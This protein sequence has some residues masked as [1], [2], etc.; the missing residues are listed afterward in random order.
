MAFKIPLLEP[1]EMA[2][3][4]ESVRMDVAYWERVEAASLARKQDEG[5]KAH[6]ADVRRAL[7]NSR[8]VLKIILDAP[9]GY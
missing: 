1:N 7:K 3:V 4:I 2:V 6:L 5:E 8:H 9:G